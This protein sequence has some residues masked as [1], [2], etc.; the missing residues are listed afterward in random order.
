IN[1]G[2]ARASV[3]EGD[4]AVTFPVT[5]N[6]QALGVLSEVR[7][8]AGFR[9]EASLA[10]GLSPPAVAPVDQI[11]AWRRSKLLYNGAPLREVLADAARYLSEDME[12]D[13]S[14][15][16]VLDQAVRGGFDAVDIDGLLATLDAVYP[17]SIDRSDPAKIVVRGDAPETP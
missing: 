7:L 14:A 4:V 15:D 8:S 5:V 2:V 6:G 9:V 12:I 16:A 10:A 17:I 3:A 13:P 11:A 1:G